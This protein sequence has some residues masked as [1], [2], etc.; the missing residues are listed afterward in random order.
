V[1]SQPHG[2]EEIIMHIYAVIFDKVHNTTTGALHNVLQ[3]IG[4]DYDV[5]GYNNVTLEKIEE[6]MGQNNKP[7]LIL[8]YSGGIKRQIPDYNLDKFYREDEPKGKKTTN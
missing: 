8:Y 3:M 4:Y 6:S 1:V 2:K 7:I 5:P